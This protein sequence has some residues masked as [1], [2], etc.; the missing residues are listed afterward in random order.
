MKLIDWLRPGIKV[1]R[2]V[3]LAIM[4]ILLIVFG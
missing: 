4:G 3:L 2:W 1:K